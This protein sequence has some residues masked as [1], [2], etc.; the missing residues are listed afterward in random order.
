MRY[1]S[2]YGSKN[3]LQRKKGA[4][5]DQNVLMT[6]RAYGGLQLLETFFTAGISYR[7]FDSQKTAT[8]W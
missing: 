8:Y 3:G 5:M 7:N 4:G 2:F 6:G 1:S